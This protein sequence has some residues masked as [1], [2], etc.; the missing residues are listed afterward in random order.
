M[1]ERESLPAAN[2]E[3]PNTTP[4]D[5]HNIAAQHDQLA[6]LRRR[7]AAAVRLDGANPDPLYTGRKFHCPSTGLR[8]AG[9]RQGYVAAIRYVLREFGE[10]LGEIGRAKLAAIANRS[11]E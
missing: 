8:A 10:Y 3:A 11:G 7:R 2:E 4:D 1:P 5:S 9:Y 6:D